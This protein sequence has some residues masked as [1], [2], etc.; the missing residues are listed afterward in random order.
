MLR[1]RSAVSGNG[2][3]KGGYR[4]GARAEVHH[5]G[6]GQAWGTVTFD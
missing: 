6:W 3:L 4:D 2:M 5:R 1:V